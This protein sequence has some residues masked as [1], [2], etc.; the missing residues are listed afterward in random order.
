MT[1]IPALLTT[2]LRLCRSL[3]TEASLALVDNDWLAVDESLHEAATKLGRHLDAEETVL[4]PRL[5]GGDLKADA[6]LA[7][8]RREHEAIRLRRRAACTAAYE[9]DTVSCAQA[10]S[11]LTN[12]LD[13][14]WMTEHQRL[15]PLTISL[16]GAV[17][18]ELAQEL[19]KP[20][21]Q[22]SVSCV[23]HAHPNKHSLR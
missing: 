6:A 13:G 8:C 21:A 5:A 16:D 1:T 4:F 11:E 19:S 18:I 22:P 9:R 12:L 3:L 7:R 17:L 15:F 23:M 14:H 20:T 10:L 2:G